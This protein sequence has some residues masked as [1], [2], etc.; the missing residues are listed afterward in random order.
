MAVEAA[1]FHQERLRR[2][3]DDYD[4]WIR[5]LLEEGLKCP[6]PEYARCKQHQKQL[7]REMEDCFAGVEILL[8]PAT[9]GPAPDASSTGDP[10]FNSPRAGVRSLQAASKAA[11]P[12]DG[13]LLRRGRD[14]A[15]A[16]DDRPG[17]GRE[18]HRRSRLQF[19]VELHRLSD[20]LVPRRPESRWHAAGDSACRS[21]VGR[22]RTVPRRRVVRGHP[23]RRSR[24]AAA[25][26]K[27]F[28]FSESCLCSMQ[29][30]E[31]MA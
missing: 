18:Q 22:A 3:P 14:I 31:K 4:P 5:G 17:P 7:R 20:D 24:R 6:A 11:A 15:Y 21:H 29:C 25:A 19:A 16:G 2:H 9:T 26:L 23:W 12:R 28:P 8:T 13:G 30:I 1:A 10:A 27:V